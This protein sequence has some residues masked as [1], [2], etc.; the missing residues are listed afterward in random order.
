VLLSEVRALGVQGVAGPAGVQVADG[1]QLMR[2][3][4]WLRT[5]TRVL[6][7]MG[8]PFHATSFPE[9]VRKASALPWERFVPGGARVAFHVTCHKSRLYH[10]GAVR[11]RLHA[12]LQQ[13]IGREAAIAEEGQLFVARFER[14]LCTVS[15]D[16]SGALLHQR[17]WR[18]PA[19]KAPL[20]ETLAAAL[21]LAARYEGSEPL[22]DPFC[23]SGTIAVEAAHIA[24]RRAPGLSREFAFMRWPRFDAAAFEKLRAEARRGERPAPAPIE[25]SD[26]DGGAVAAARENAARAGVAIAVSQ[27]RAADLPGDAAAGLLACNPP[28]GVRVAAGSAYRDLAEAIKRRPAWRV[29]AVVADKARLSGLR[30]ERL[31]RTQ[32]GGLWVE[33]LEGRAGQDAFHDLVEQH[34]KRSR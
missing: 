25:A 3:N 34:H 11:E 7:R 18:G 29:A 31:A 30:W 15:A 8:E 13:R 2:L 23:G 6:V 19:A 20:R 32:N 28:Y 21:L 5:A 24:M 10:S 9:L 27:R 33:M 22:C 16:S 4:L 14:D 12:A 26:Q 1:G 17:G